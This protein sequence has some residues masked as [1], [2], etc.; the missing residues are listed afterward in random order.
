MDNYFGLPKTIYQNEDFLVIDKP[1]NL[2][3]QVN[4]DH[5]NSLEK[6]LG[7]QMP[8]LTSLSR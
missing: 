3:V 8:Q 1:N 2:S 6:I 7:E 4:K 5:P